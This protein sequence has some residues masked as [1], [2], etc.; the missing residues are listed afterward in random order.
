VYAAAWQKGY[1]PQTILV[2]AVTDFG[3]GYQPKNFNLKEN[4]PVSMKQALATSLNIPAVKTLYLAGVR[5]ATQLAARMG[6]ESLN[7]PDRYGL[8]LVLGGG[9]VRLLDE[10]SAYGVFA[11]E[12]MK[13]PSRALLKVEHGSEVLFDASAE[14]IKEDKILD[15]NVARLVNDALSDNAARAPAFGGRS[16]LQLGDRPVA[17]KTG[18][19]QEF[20]DGW[21]V[22]YT[23]SLAAGV[24]VGNNDNSPMGAKEPG[25]TTAAPLWNKFM[26]AALRGKPIER[27][28]PPQ[29]RQDLRH[30]ILQGKLPEVK[31]KWEEATETLFSID[32]PIETSSVKTFIE[33]HDIL[34]YVR[35]D[36]PNGD[37]PARA[38]SDPQFDRWESAVAA[39]RDKHNTEHAKDASKPQY[40]G[41]LP[42]PTC[43]RDDVG[44]A[45]KI[46]ITEPDTTILTENPVKVV[47]EIESPHSIKE[48]RFI[49]DGKEIARRGGEGPYEASFS[50]PSGF[51]G[52]KTLLITAV[53]ENNLLGRAHRTFIINPDDEPPTIILHTPRNNATFK[54][55]DFP[56]TIKI[57]AT[58]RSDIEAVDVLYRKEGQGGTQRI[59][60][61]TTPTKTA[62]R[63]EVVWDD[64]PGPGNYTVYAVAYDRTGNT[65]E[66]AQHSIT[67]SE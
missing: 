7:D 23:P 64:S 56:Q 17:A 19:T 55:S 6:M 61:T 40:V 22:G 1:T 43:N 41:S 26:R 31:G 8:S 58:D 5:N 51:S 52:R 67:I 38:E 27:F 32:C 44:D 15:A 39:W 37:P 47:V 10:V 33:L 2:D 60:R 62:H 20:R 25:A 16:A 42:T 48:V 13:R 3:Q 45:P 18:T 63:Y 36:N 28:T 24:W 65:A 57:T 53:T 21:T 59:G 35:R 49:F 46:R 50:F 29:P 30:E 12:G 54:A 66:T 14:E 11:A 34:Y 9:E 4:G